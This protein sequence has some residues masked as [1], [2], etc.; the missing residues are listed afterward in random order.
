MALLLINLVAPDQRIIGLGL[1]VPS[2][3]LPKVELLFAEPAMGDLALRS[4]LIELA[5]LLELSPEPFSGFRTEA[6]A[7]DDDDGDHG[8]V[9]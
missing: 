6:Q 7:R 9:S 5:R 3:V 8:L 1:V 2:K 4:R